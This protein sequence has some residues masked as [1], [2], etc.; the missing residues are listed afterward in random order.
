MSSGMRVRYIQ[1]PASGDC[2]LS[3]MKSMPASSATVAAIFYWLVSADFVRAGVVIA[4]IA[5]LGWLS[6]RMVHRHLPEGESA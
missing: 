3:Y 4:A 5:L 6:T 2:V 1:K